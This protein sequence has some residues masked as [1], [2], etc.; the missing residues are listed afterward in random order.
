MRKITGDDTHEEGLA[1]EDLATTLPLDD[2]APSVIE[3]PDREFCV[4]GRFAFGTRKKVVEA[5]VERGGSCNDTPRGMTAY[6]VVGFF[7]SKD[8]KYSSYGTKI[9]RAVQLRTGG[10][11]RIVAEEHWRRFLV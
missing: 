8:W 5:I 10:K 7:A 6:V 2:P 4:T 1:A 3:F 11:L 9:E